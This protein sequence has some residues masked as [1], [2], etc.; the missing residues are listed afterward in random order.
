LEKLVEELTKLRGKLVDDR[1]DDTTRRERADLERD[2]QGLNAKL[3]SLP[4]QEMVYAAASQFSTQGSFAAPRTPRP[5]HLLAR[6]DVRSPKQL[7]APAGVTCVQGPPSAFS[8]ADS[9]DEGQRRA[10]LARWL[11]DPRNALLRRSIVNRVWQYHFGQG[12]VDTPNDFGRM[13]SPPSHPELLEWL[14]GWFSEHGHSLKSLHR[15][16]VT[17]AA[18]RQSSAGKPEY[19]KIDSGNRYLWRMN[20]Q[21]LDAECIRDSVLAVAGKL[22]LTMG[23]PSAQQ[24][25]FKDDHSPI[26]DYARF[27]VDDPRSFRRSIYRFLVRSV[28]DPFMECL[29]CADPSIMTPKR[30]TT[31]TSIQALALLNNPL[32]TRQAEHF[33]Q[34]LRTL[35][36]DVPGQIEA[37]YLLALGRKPSEREATGMAAYAQEFGLANACRVI[38]N[39]NE[40]VF[41][42]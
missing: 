30:N 4:K 23:G 9:N 21:R 2:L 42:D 38:F 41:V 34:R 16:L 13:G 24:F 12:L 22:D 25:Y 1:L 27:D 14:A 39:S 11:T 40:F 17:S 15:L 18:Y 5:I 7:V 35:C 28:P 26:Y 33:A 32:A 6:G 3:S 8:L 19:A 37:A 10:A 20:R 29:D 31:L 36:S